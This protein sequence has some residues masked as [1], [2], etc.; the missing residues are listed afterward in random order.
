MSGLDR[1]D[2]MALVWHPDRDE[3]T[4]VGRLLEA[5]K[6]RGDDA[7]VAMLAADMG[8]WA[9]TIAPPADAVVVP[10]PA[11]ADRP[12]RL[13]PAL[14]DAIGESWSLPVFAGLVRER[15]TPRLRDLEP[16]ARPAMAEAAGYRVSEGFGATTVVLI[17]DVV[18]TASTLE[19]LAQVM[20]RA[21]VTHV[22]AVVLARA[23]RS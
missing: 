13:V 21:G 10:V 9:P 5:A 11:S 7:A 12:N 18:L 4:P 23:R 6:E 2:V 15:N 17:D 22:R 14:A 16:A 1:I 20:R 8:A 3:R 19:H